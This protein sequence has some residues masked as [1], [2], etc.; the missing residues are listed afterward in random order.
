MPPCGRRVRRGSV[1]AE[2]RHAVL[3]VVG[4][5][6]AQDGTQRGD[7]D[8]TTE[9]TEERDDGAGRAQVGGRHLVLRGEHQVLHHH[10]DAETHHEHEDRDVPVLGVVPDGA[11]HPETGGE[12]E[13]TADQPCLPAARLGDDLARQG[14][15]QEESGDHR[16]RHDAGHRRRLAPRQLEVLAEEDGAREHSD[17]DEQR[18]RGGQRDG[19]VTEEAQRDDRLACLGLDRQEQADEHGGAGEHRPGLPGDPVVLVAREGH[20]EQQQRDACC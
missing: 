3:D 5:A 14:R 20:P 15:G 12:Q 19:A 11:Q 1:G 7:A 9:G 17:T 6:V 10:A 16:D 2:A 13:A 8:G 18:G 4:D